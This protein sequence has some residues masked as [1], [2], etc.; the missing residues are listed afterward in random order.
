MAAWTRWGNTI[1]GTIVNSIS[2]PS[3]TEKKVKNKTIIK[4]FPEAASFILFLVIITLIFINGSN[5][6]N[7]AVEI[8][9]S[10]SKIVSGR[11]L[12]ISYSVK[13]GYEVKYEF[14]FEGQFYF[15]AYSSSNIA[16]LKNNI[17][18][19]WFP[20]IFKVD[21]P[22]KNQIMIMPED[23][24]KFGVPFPDTLYWIKQRLNSVGR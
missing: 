6:S 13:H 3:Q 12:G 14:Y 24:D 19:K 4:R 21:D 16:T 2:S 15:G 9:K 18:D 10:N 5:R 1:S 23:F 17:N 11:V 7:K 8:I 20:V 22:V